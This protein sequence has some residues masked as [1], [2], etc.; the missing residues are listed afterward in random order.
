[1]ALSVQLAVT[2]DRVL[3]GIGDA[4]VGSVLNLADGS[5]LADQARFTDAVNEL[6]GTPNTGVTWVD[7]AGAI[8]AVSGLMGPMLPAPE[9]A[10]DWLGPLDAFVSVARLDGSVLVQRSAILTE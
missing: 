8:D 2:D 7:I 6:G 3:I 5:S 10:D 9:G 1:M 4:F